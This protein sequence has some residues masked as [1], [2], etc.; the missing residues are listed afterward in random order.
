M[1]APTSLGVTRTAQTSLGK[2]YAVTFLNSL[3]TGVVT[4]G[5]FFLTKNSFGFTQAQNFILGIVLGVT[6]IFGAMGAGSAISV[7]KG[8]FPS[9]TARAL[10]FW[11]Q[12]I[13]GLCCI[14]PLAAQ[15]FTPAGQTIPQ[16]PIWALILIYSPLTGLLWPMV[17]HYLSGGR[18]GQELRSGMGMWNVVWSSAVVLSYWGMSPLVESHA[19]ETIL[20]LGGLHVL[21]AFM[22]M[23]FA[24][25]PAEHVH[26]TPGDSDDPSHDPIVY[27][28]LLYTLRIL[29]PLCYVVS[30]TLVPYLPDA[31][32]KLDVPVPW[33]AFIASAW[34][35][36]RVITFYV[37]QRWHGW[38]GRWSLPIIGGLLMLGGFCV[39]V[40]APLL[41]RLFNLSTVSATATLV[42]GLFAFGT[43]MASIYTGA[44]Y[45]AMEATH[46][47]VE[48]GG[49]HEALIGLGYTVG[50]ICGLI[51]TLA[52]DQRLIAPNTFQP[53]L[54][55]IVLTIALIVSVYVIA[56]IRK[57]AP[58][59]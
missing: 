2:L 55:G 36:P 30:S 49:T 23:G 20:V 56:H 39:A 8:V 50:P 29:L 1:D 21:A 32:F 58:S 48:A 25:E 40:A 47:K 41:P 34:L 24:V 43:G 28:K 14:I 15:F 5:I 7:L 38:H 11:I 3:G 54:I 57:H 37:L 31:F 44:L 13:L 10:L 35:V 26:A 4:N 27:S 59:R 42:L 33:Q 17:E 51:P 19:V 22:T 6:Y 12:A 46:E 18:R 53:L 9:L 16:W 45:Y 52:V